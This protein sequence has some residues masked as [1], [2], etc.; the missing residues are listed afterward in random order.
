MS[1]ASGSET[2]ARPDFR[3]VMTAMVGLY[4]RTGGSF[5][6]K[7][8]GLPVL[9]LTTTGRKTGQPRKFALI[10]ARDGDNYLVVASKGGAP[11]HPGA[12]TGRRLTAETRPRWPCSSS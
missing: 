9:L 3:S 12:Q 2:P 5:G 7:V 10:Y 4:R 8:Q 11:A 1:S 6:G